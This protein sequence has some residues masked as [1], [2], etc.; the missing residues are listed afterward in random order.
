[1]SVS[2]SNGHAVMGEGERLNKTV[3]VLLVYGIVE[4]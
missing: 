3:G 4:H 2:F 1:M